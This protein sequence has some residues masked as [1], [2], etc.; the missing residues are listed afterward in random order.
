[1][2]AYEGIMSMFGELNSEGLLLMLDPSES[3]SKVL[4][5]I[6]NKIA[7]RNAHVKEKTENVLWSQK[8]STPSNSH[9][10]LMKVTWETSIEHDARTASE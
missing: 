10:P 7:S 6:E 2:K 8:K 5:C 4:E 9:R 1:M 3:S